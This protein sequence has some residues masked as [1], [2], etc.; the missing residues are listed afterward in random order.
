MLLAVDIGN[1]AIKAGVFSGD[2][3]IQRITIDTADA[4]SLGNGIDLSIDAAIISSVVPPLTSVA[5]AAVAAR[6]GV[7]V[8]VLQ[9]DRDLGIKI[10]YHPLA[11]A[12][13]DRL[14]NSSA[15]AYLYGV[16]TIVVSFGTATTIDIVDR[17][18]ILIG[19]LIAPGIRMTAKA[20]HEKTARLPLVEI[21]KSVEAINL[22]TETSIQAGVVFSQIGLLETV[23]PR[24]TQK[25]GKAAVV[26]TG[27]YAEMISRH[28]QLIDIV[29]GDLLLKGL[30]R[31]ARQD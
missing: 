24:V 28:T 3:L 2:R 5:A 9:N 1:T 27:G 29:D 23:V 17:D 13:T 21:P 22:T 15:A 31:I 6:F 19:G 25:I 10:D 11:D 4:A 18:L 8:D 16:P 12:G 20:L 14:V 26:A 7:T 30:A